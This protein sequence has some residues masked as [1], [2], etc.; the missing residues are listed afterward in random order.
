MKGQ[1]ILEV[2]DDLKVEHFRHPHTDRPTARQII[3]SK[4]G[5]VPGHKGSVWVTWLFERRHCGPLV[6]RRVR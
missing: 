3:P 4:A 6:W 5:R 1:P 2:G